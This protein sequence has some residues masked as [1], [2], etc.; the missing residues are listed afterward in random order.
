VA[1]SKAY[2]EDAMT[3]ELR[4]TIVDFLNSAAT[5][6]AT[7][8]TKTVVCDECGAAK[9]NRMSTFFYDGQP[10]ELLVPICVKCHPTLHVITHDA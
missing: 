1:K 3:E 8:S 4:E 2:V 6:S 10:W 5:E 9:E 7:T